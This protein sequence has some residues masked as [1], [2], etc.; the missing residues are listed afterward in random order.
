MRVAGVK[1][2][3]VVAHEE[4]RERR[5]PVLAPE[6]DTRLALLAGVLTLRRMAPAH[7]AT[8]VAFAA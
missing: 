3:A 7:D 5:A 4:G 6:L 2:I 1:A 8:L